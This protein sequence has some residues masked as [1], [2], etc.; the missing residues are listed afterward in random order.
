V[1]HLF[2]R[3][4]SILVESDLKHRTVLIVLV[5]LLASVLSVAVYANHAAYA[6]PGS[7][8]GTVLWIDQYGNAR[9]MAWAEITADDGISSPHTTYTT[10]GTYTMWL[11]EGT[12]NM[13]A[14]SSPGFYADSKS[15]IVVSPGSSTN[16]DFTLRPT[17]VPVP[18]LPPWSQPI[19]V[20]G[21]LMI[22]VVAVRRHKTRT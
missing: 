6:A 10:D 20:L 15:E 17:G 13:T 12:Y 7:V 19:I 9:P 8:R 4:H 21:A 18:E 14:S 22:T 5:A 11:P 1:K 3:F 2:G 16:I